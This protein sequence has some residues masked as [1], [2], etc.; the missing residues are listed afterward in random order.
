MLPLPLCRK[1]LGE[2]GQSLSDTDIERLRDD[3][4]GLAHIMTSSYMQDQSKPRTSSEG[5]QNGK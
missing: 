3:L 4:Y 2:Y 5:N 1:L